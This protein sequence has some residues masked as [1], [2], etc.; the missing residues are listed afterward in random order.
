MTK[1]R[2]ETARFVAAILDPRTS[3]YPVFALICLHVVTWTVFLA[4]ARS[5]ETLNSD[6]TEMFAWGRLWL[7]GYGKHPP[8]AGW[9]ARIWFE[10]FPTAD[11]AMHALVMTVVGVAA[12]ACWLLAIR[13]VDRRRAAVV[14]F[15]LLIYP[16][17]NFRG[18][19]YGTD[20][21]LVPM[22]MLVALVFLI[23]F[24]RRTIAWGALLGLACAAAVLTKYWALFIVGAVGVAAIAHPERVRF[25][26][27]WT[28]YVATVVFLAAIAPHLIWLVQS[29]YAPFAYAAHHLAQSTY[30][31]L[32]QAGAE[33]RHHAALLLPAGVAL[34]WVIARNRL[35]GAASGVRLG[36]ARHIWLIAGLLLVLPPVMTVA[37]RVDF[38]VDWG[39]PLYT[40][41]PLALLAVPQLAIARR[42]VAS[43]A[44]VW[45][46][47]LALALTAA[48]IVQT[49]QVKLYPQRY[50]ENLS[51]V[52]AQVTRLWR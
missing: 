36:Q 24:E 14:V 47:T 26:R 37:F 20:L 29:D 31:P 21:P 1:L 16:I 48:P 38:A 17:F 28:P 43:A 19:R 9:I 7:W 8:V 22:F 10:I 5:G 42:A 23:A 15:V 50:Q 46:A 13:V 51:D 45:I 35:P 41:L 27:A 30:S 44:T 12:W 3:S 33:L 49:V 4:I 11:W 40:L 34:A 6:S 25:F 52:A 18:A 39:L 2:R 32:L